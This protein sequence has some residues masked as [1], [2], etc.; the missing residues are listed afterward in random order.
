GL[1]PGGNVSAIVYEDYLQEN[2]WPR[3]QGMDL[4]QFFTEAYYRKETPVWGSLSE[5]TFSDAKSDPMMLMR[6]LGLG[7]SLGVLVAM[8]INAIFSSRR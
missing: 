6:L 5:G 4:K 7:L 8:A 3:T 1:G 2:G